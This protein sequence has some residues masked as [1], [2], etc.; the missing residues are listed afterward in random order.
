MNFFFANPDITKSM[1][2]LNNRSILSLAFIIGQ[3]VQKQI[4]QNMET[5]SQINE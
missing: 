5:Q 4:F 1:P 2:E 3:K